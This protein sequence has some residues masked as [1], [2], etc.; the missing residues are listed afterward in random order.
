LHQEQKETPQTLRSGVGRLNLAKLPLEIL[1]GNLMFPTSS[2]LPAQA[3]W[4]SKTRLPDPYSSGI[5]PDA[6]FSISQ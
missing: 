1:F 4:L 6:G 2:S 3:P 5:T